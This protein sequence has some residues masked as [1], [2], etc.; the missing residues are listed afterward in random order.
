MVSTVMLVRL[1][2][3]W[4]AGRPKSCAATHPETC[5]ASRSRACASTCGAH[6][7]RA[8]LF[9]MRAHVMARRDLDLHTKHCAA[10][11]TATGAAR[12]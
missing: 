3:I 8:P 12:S 1:L 6:K 9:T 11:M 2:L 5:G 4:L 7:G 10:Q